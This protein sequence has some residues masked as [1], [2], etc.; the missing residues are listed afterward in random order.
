SL[1]D[2]NV[3]VVR[4]QITPVD[5][6][7]P[8]TLHATLDGN[9]DNLGL[10]HWNKVEQGHTDQ[11]TIFLQSATRA[12]GI[13]LCEAARL[14][15]DGTPEVDYAVHQRENVP[16]IVARF[17]GKQGQTV[18]AEKVVSLF[19]SHDAGRN[20][21]TAA[22]AKLVEVTRQGPTYDRLLRASTQA[23]EA[24]WAASGVE[25]VGDGEAQGSTRHMS[26]QLLS[27]A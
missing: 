23:W 19:T 21:R 2:K 16:T 27:A 14:Q 22:L 20:T 13:T 1:A 18:T 3:L 15:V 26:C 10:S 4:C 11:Q 8:I 6:S 25:I 24:Y 7:G 12:T 17:Q 9:V 5:F